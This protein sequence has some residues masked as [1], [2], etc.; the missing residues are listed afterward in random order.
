MS[1]K[2]KVSA[3]LVVTI[4][5]LF[6]GNLI[7]K[8]LIEKNNASSKFEPLLEVMSDAKDFE[9]LYDVNDKENSQLS[10]VADTVVGVYKETSGLG[11]VVLLSTTQ[12]YTHEPI[13]FTVAFSPEGIITNIA[14]TNYPESKD[15]GKNTYPQTYIGQDST[16]AGVSI[17][18]GVTFSSSA[19]KNATLDA[20]N[21]LT[22]NNLV[23]AGKMSDDQALTQLL[24]TAFTSMASPQGV[25]QYEESE[26]SEGTLFKAFKALNDGGYAF[27]AKEDDTT[28]M[29][30]VNNDG[31][32]KVVDIDGND[33]TEAHSQVVAD[34]LNYVNGKLAG[35]AKKE[36]KK[37]SKL[38]E[39]DLT[40]I[41]MNGVYN[42]V[43]K[44]YSTSAGDYAFI[45]KTYGYSNQVMTSYYVIDANGNIK[46][47]TVDE[48]ILQ[49]EY[50]DS[51]T[52][53]EDSYKAGFV[54]QNGSTYT[55]DVALISG[56]TMS[57]NAIDMATKDA[58][59]AF[60]IIKGE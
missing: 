22:A 2:L 37:L 42:S 60:A 44:A 24:T 47:M 11:Y 55:S 8:P 19:F 9:V 50:F 21:V 26:I 25:A 17:V 30:L 1:N 36:V 10:D 45:V 31:C 20:F 41:V 51:Y 49:K 33:V 34:A 56:A 28:T 5:I 15:F 39:A 29:A 59:A 48:I 6:A 14:L 58:L 7:T 13:N 12:G 53:D 3:I 38:A 43:V 16:L 23:E 52:L 32:V 18:A 27:L 57:T 54:G 4:A 40:E 46:A 35:A